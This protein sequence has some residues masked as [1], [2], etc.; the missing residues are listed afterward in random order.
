[1]TPIDDSSVS[2]TFD[3]DC[4]AADPRIAKLRWERGGG[5]W[6]MPMS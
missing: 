5:A 2:V 6:P 4:F 3:R 1:M